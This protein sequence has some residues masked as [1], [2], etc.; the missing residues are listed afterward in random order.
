MEISEMYFHGFFI[1]AQLQKMVV[2]QL[3]KT[4]LVAVCCERSASASPTVFPAKSG[5][6]SW[7]FH[8]GGSSA[9]GPPALWCL[10]WRHTF[11]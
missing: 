5:Y 6:V 4:Y 10:L 3:L 8:S 7:R 2:D 11:T 9:A 1:V